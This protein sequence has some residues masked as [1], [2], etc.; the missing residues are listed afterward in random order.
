MDDA[1]T[2]Y[3]AYIGGWWLWGVYFTKSFNNGTNWSSPQYLAD[4]YYSSGVGDR[5]PINSL[6]ATGNG[7]LFL[8]WVDERYGTWDILGMGSTNGGLSWTGPFVV[9]DITDGGQCKGW[10]TFDPYGGLHTFWY[11]TSSWP[12]TTSSQWEVRYQYSADS[13][14]TFSPSVRITD[15]VFLGHYYDGYTN[16]MG[17]YH[18]IVADSHYVYAV[19]TDGRDGNMNLYFSRALLPQSCLCGDFNGN[20]DVNVGDLTALA[21]YLIAGGSSPNCDL[22]PNSDGVWSTSDLVF[23]AGYFFDGGPPPCNGVMRISPASP[24]KG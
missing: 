1:G 11:H 4:V 10:V 22:D 8:T 17:D 7:I 3:M 14:L 5:A 24:V 18:T 12:T 20:G 2:L 6:A 19:W 15:T 13:G 9:N 21:I 16:F 23:L